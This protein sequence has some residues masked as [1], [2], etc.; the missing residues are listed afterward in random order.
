VTLPVLSKVLPAGR[1]ATS[2]LA[3]RPECS[4]AVSS[5]RLC[6]TADS[7]TEQA[8]RQQYLLTVGKYL[9]TVKKNLILSQKLNNLMYKIFVLQNASF[10]PLR[11]SS[12]CSHHQEVKI[13]LHS[14]WYLHTLKWDDTR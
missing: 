9:F 12:T 7:Q 4:S 14:L 5:S 13:A 1:P 6:D 3:N 10:L 2:R 11:F 8:D